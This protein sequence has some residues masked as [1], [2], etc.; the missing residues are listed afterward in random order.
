[1]LTSDRAD[2]CPW[3]YQRLAFARLSAH[4]RYR[5]VES[6]AGVQSEA[7]VESE[8]GASF[9]RLLIVHPLQVQTWQCSLHNA[10]SGARLVPPQVPS[11]SVPF[12]LGQPNRQGRL[13]DSEPRGLKSRPR[14]V[15][16]W[17]VGTVLKFN[18]GW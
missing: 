12:L 5:A 2:V 4:S 14:G 18:C 7:G 3:F 6:E 13:S 15:A 17:L 16:E 11:E 8:A 10:C 1:M 9:A